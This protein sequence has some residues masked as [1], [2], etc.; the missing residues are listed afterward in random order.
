MEIYWNYLYFSKYMNFAFN[1]PIRKQT[2]NRISNT[3]FNDTDFINSTE[4][5]VPRDLFFSQ[6]WQFNYGLNYESISLRFN[7]AKNG[8]VFRIYPTG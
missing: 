3:I 8:T 4:I 2:V 7:F 1:F 5:A 6:F